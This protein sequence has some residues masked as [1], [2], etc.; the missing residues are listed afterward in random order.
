MQKIEYLET[1]AKDD[2]S[3]DKQKQ[4]AVHGMSISQMQM[5]LTTKNPEIRRHDYERF[6]NG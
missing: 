3:S 5:S 1:K 6:P 2:L 4:S